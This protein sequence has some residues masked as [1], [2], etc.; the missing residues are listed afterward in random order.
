MCLNASEL[1]PDEGKVYDLDE[2]ECRDETED[3]C[4]EPQTWY[5]SGEFCAFPWDICEDGQVYDTAGYCRE[6]RSSDCNE[7]FE[8]VVTDHGE[9]YC[10][11]P[12]GQ[13]YDEAAFEC[14]YQTAADCDAPF[15]WYKLPDDTHAC[16]CPLGTMYKESKNQCV[17]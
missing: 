11:C 17:T 16:M 13:I 5:E 7:P 8:W 6:I 9:E 4:V 3:D 15:E 2:A 12:E 1:C 14:R 10:G